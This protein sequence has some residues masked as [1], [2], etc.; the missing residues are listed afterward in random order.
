MNAMDKRLK[1]HIDKLLR[2]YDEARTTDE[3]EREL[4]DFFSQPHD[5]LPEEWERYAALFTAFAQ[6]DSLFSEAESEEM[7]AP[8]PH[9]SRRVWPWTLGAAAAIALLIG[10]FLHQ[11]HTTGARLLGHRRTIY[12][13]YRR[14]GHY[15]GG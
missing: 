7:T 11:P 13:E 4:A 12:T 3:Q 9:R 8:L 5:T 1:E 15:H 2:L 14:V 6:S 10:L